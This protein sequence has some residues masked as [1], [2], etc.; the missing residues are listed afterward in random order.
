MESYIM[1]SREFKKI[2]FK[3][4]AKLN[5]FV[6]V[7]LI[8]TWSTPSFCPLT[9]GQASSL[10]E[11]PKDK[12]NLGKVLAAVQAEPKDQTTGL[13]ILAKAY[14]V[15]ATKAALEAKLQELIAAAV[16][17]GGEVPPATP[18]PAAAPRG[19]TAELRAELAA[20]QAAA[21]AAAAGKD[22]ELAAVR[23]ELAAAQAA[24]AA[25]V[26]DA[27]RDGEAKGVADT[28]AAKDGEIAAIRAQLVAKDG[29][30]AAAA[31]ANAAAVADARRDGEAKGVADT[32]AAKDGEI[33]A[34]R[35]QLAAKE[36]ELTARSHELGQ[37][38]AAL[39]AARQEL[40]DIRNEL[41]EAVRSGEEI[42]ETA[43]RYFAV[44]NRDGYMDSNGHIMPE[45]DI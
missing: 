24:T 27:R 34:I 2:N 9:F 39:A 28:T 44:M 26:A 25:A 37:V 40:I 45:Y 35:A 14:G 30:L 8:L 3:Q 23:G 5:F 19:P 16:G 33:A 12:V 22:G 10:K 36:A 11:L 29:E 4:I 38:Q 17:G 1:K 20:A 13:K 6:I 7:I 21:V 15:A 41:V 31:A 32:T 18:P 42:T 43:G